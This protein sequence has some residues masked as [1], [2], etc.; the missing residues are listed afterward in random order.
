MRTFP[1]DLLCQLT[2][3]VF[4]GFYQRGDHYYIDF[5]LSCTLFGMNTAGKDCIRIRTRGGI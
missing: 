4:Q 3:G 1:R 2:C 5:N